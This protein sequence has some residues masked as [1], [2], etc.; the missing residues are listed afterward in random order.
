MRAWIAVTLTIGVMPYALYRWSGSLWPGVAVASLLFAVLLLVDSLFNELIATLK[1]Q[2]S[3]AVAELLR[4]LAGS[5]SA[6]M[7]RLD[8]IEKRLTQ[9]SGQLD[10]FSPQRTR[11][12]R[13]P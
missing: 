9:I 1:V 5:E 13:E 6:P 12:Q 8:N 4:N 2:V 7:I 3:G 10:S 11:P